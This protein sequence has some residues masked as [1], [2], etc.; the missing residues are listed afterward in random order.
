VCLDFT[1][2]TFIA[3]ACT[4]GL[5]CAIVN[6]HMAPVVDALRAADVLLGHDRRAMSFLRAYRARM[7]EKAEGG[8]AV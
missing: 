5:T 8:A 2:A 3:M 4:A 1:D 7:K 6:P